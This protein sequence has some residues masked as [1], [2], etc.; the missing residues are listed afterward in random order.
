VVDVEVELGGAA[1]FPGGG[2]TIIGAAMT[3]D[4]TRVEAVGE[5]LGS[6]GRGLLGRFVG[7]SRSKAA[8]GES[9]GG[10]ELEPREELRVR[11][12]G[13]EIEAGRQLTHKQGTQNVYLS[14]YQPLNRMSTLSMMNR[15]YFV[16]CFPQT[17]VQ[18]GTLHGD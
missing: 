15:K 8:E 14:L 6:A 1:G 13:D 16:L 10:S 17:Y 3:G 9:G 7:V 4:V 11:V 2:V 18:V 12:M 5:R